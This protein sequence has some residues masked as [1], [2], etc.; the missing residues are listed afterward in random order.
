[1]HTNI[2]YSQT[3]L[4]RTQNKSES[5]KN[6][7]S[8]KVPMYEIFI[9]LTC[10]NRKLVYSE[11]KSWPQGGLICTGL[12]VFVIVYCI[13]TTNFSATRENQRRQYLKPR[14]HY[15]N[16]FS[17]SDISGVI[18]I[19]YLYSK[20]GEVSILNVLLLSINIFYFPWSRSVYILI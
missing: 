14:N 8:N 10:I 6:Q 19:I 3:F 1:M 15:W 5:C 7:T 12:T 13:L 11:H 9:N 2:N 4:H 18:D 20:E 17:T 16:C